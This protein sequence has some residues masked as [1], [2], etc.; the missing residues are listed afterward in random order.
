MADAGST[1]A[2]S[3]NLINQPG[4]VQAGFFVGGQFDSWGLTGRKPFP[5][6][7]P[8]GSGSSTIVM[9]R[10]EGSLKK[11]CSGEV[12]PGAVGGRGYNNR[13]PNSAIPDLSPLMR[14]MCPEISSALIFSTR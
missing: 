7:L 6:A 13:A 5:G 2:A 3:T 1:P 4:L 14:V 8:G 9:G 10:R 11:V 12:H